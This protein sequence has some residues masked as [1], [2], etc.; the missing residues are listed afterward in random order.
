MIAQL[1]SFGLEPV[2]KHFPYLPTGANLHRQ[3]PD[4]RLPLAE[5]EQRFAIFGE[6]SDDAGIMMT[7]HL[8]DSLVDK[9]IVTFSPLWNGL[10]RRRRDSTG[11]LMSDGLLMLK[12]YADSRSSPADPGPGFAGIDETARWAMRAILAGHD[13]VIVE[14]SAAQTYHVFEGLLTVACGGTPTGRRPQGA[15][16][17][18]HTT[19]SRPGRRRTPRLCAARSMS[20]LPS[21]QVG[22]RRPAGGR[23]PTWHPSRSRRERWRA[24]SLPSCRRAWSGKAMTAAALWV[25]FSLSLLM[26]LS[27][28]LM[29]GPLLTYTIARTLRTPRG[30]WLT[31]RASLPATR[32]SRRACS[33][34][35]AGVVEFLH[36]PLAAKIIGVVGR[37]APS[38]HGRRADPRNGARQGNR[39]SRRREGDDGQGSRSHRQRMHPVLAGALV[40][41]SNPYWWIWWVTIGSAFLLRFEITLDRWQALLAFFVGHELGDL[42]WYSA[43]SIILHLGRKRIPRGVAAAIIGVCGVAIIAFAVYLGISPFLSH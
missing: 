16:R 7:T 31:A 35:R 42:G 20:R 15:H 1:R 11:L 12:N 37:R 41:M 23:T 4:T 29:P 2:I 5:A 33:R 26:S 6:L 43:V 3:S 38:V 40:S 32:R 21:M 28:A 17:G 30:G 13:M 36:A 9:S 8:Y 22:D 27:G 10:L 24:C 19:G 39:A 18:M 14:G 34:P 25:V